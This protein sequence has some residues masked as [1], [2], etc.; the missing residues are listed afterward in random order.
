MHID[1]QED[2]TMKSTA[3]DETLLARAR[4]GDGDAFRQLVEPY[5]PELQVHC[6]RTLGSTQDAEDILQETLLAAWSALDRFDGRALRAWLYRI[7]TNRCLNH[8]RGE[9]PRRTSFGPAL[10]AVPAPSP[11]ED[12]WWLE[13]YP[14]H[15]FDMTDSRPGPEAIYD[16]RE[17]LS[18][19]FI[20]GLQTIT[21]QQRA[22]L[23]LRDVLGFS[24]SEAAEILGTS[25]ASINSTLQ[26][27]RH[28]FPRQC[29][30]ALVPQPRSTAESAVADRFAEALQSG[31]VDEIVALLTDDARFTM[32]PEPIEYRGPQA[33]GA[34]FQQLP[35]WNQPM[36]LVPTRANGQPAYAYYP[37]DPNG[38]LH[39]AGGILVL[40]LRENQIAR[41]TRF[42]DSGILARLGLP[43]TLRTDSPPMF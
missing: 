16:T 8:L 35:F 19:S 3:G 21:P 4:S 34:F 24:A 11:S 18:L 32:P 20:C 14:D 41:I 36:K 42:G 7:A 22:V 38:T 37:K 1:G 30:P 29:D 5:R 2:Q 40:T 28:N 13:P 26:R 31:N 27:A 10:S 12:P 9:S 25:Q 23:L 6:Y 15:L 17:S 39:R 43:R 33:I